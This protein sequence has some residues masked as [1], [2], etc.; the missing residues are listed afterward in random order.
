MVNFQGV[1]KNKRFDEEADWVPPK[2]R[3]FTM[4]KGQTEKEET[5]PEAPQPVLTPKVVEPVAKPVAKSEV[6]PEEEPRF[7][8]RPEGS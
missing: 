3:Q 2:G 8:V 5:I 6:K 1:R 4:K 7:K